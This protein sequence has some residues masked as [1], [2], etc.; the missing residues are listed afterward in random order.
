MMGTFIF[1]SRRCTYTVIDF[2]SRRCTSS[3]HLC[4][5]TT[6]TEQGVIMES[7]DGKSEVYRFL[8]SLP[9]GPYR[10]EYYF[11][12]QQEKFKDMRYLKLHW[13]VSTPYSTSLPIPRPSKR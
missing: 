2:I 1:P 12:V 7:V 13:K 11:A 8:S 9:I 3:L 10:K 5:C 4:N 6:N